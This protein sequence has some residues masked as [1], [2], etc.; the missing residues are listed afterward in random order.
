M[1]LADMFFG[2][3]FGELKDKFGINW[4]FNCYEKK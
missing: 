1:P 2:S 3:Y 4:M